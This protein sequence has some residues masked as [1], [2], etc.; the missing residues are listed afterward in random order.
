MCS[1]ILQS[2]LLSLEEDVIVNIECDDDN[3]EPRSF[4]ST[5]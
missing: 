2:S 1:N 5:G 3:E 4:T